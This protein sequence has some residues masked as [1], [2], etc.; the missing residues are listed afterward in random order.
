MRFYKLLKYDVKNGFR[1]GLINLLVIALFVSAF[2]VDFYLRKSG[3]YM[4]DDSTPVG[5]FIDYLFYMFAGIKEYVPSR[6]DGFIFPVKWLL[7]HLFILYSTLYYPNRDLSS[8]GLNILLRTKGRMA[9]WL[10][11]SLWNMSYVL[12]CYLVIFLTVLVFCL[13]MQEPISLNITPMF[14][15]DLLEADSP[16][17]TFSAPLV[18]I[19]LFFP[20]FISMALNLLQMTLVLFIKPLYSFGVMAVTLLASA[21]L[22]TPFLPGNYAMP[23]RSEHVVENGVQAGGGV[24]M[25]LILIATSFIAGCI[26]FRRYD[27][28]NDD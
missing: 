7:L 19:I 20:L 1:L 26:Y 14:V 9:W 10:S 23:I 6:T 5:T 16:F 18:Y 24:M 12:A 3:A 4:F 2:C 13:I 27:I 21:Y 22:L 17:D 8:L 11:K 28:L 25:V 15:N